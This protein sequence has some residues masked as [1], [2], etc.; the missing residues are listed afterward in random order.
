MERKWHHNLIHP[1]PLERP[2]EIRE[3]VKVFTAV[4]LAVIFAVTALAIK[5][6]YTKDRTQKVDATLD[7][8]KATADHVEAL[9]GKMATDIPAAVEGVTNIETGLTGM[10]GTVTGE[11]PPAAQQL[12]AN[13]LSVQGVTDD[14]RDKLFGSNGLVPGLTDSLTAPGKKVWGITVG[15]GLIPRA[16]M[17]LG[18]VDDAVLVLK[19]GA[20]G[21][22]TIVTDLD[23]SL[24]DADKIEIS[25][26][27]AITRMYPIEA[28]LTGLTDAT[29][30]TA[31]DVHKFVHTKLFP[32]PVHGFWPHVWQGVQYV[33]TPV[34]DGLKL[35]FAVRPVTPNVTFAPVTRH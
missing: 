31:E 20:E 10:I 5:G 3:W 21:L 1:D 27:G 34:F 25:A 16:T 30:G 26:D 29:T 32:P 18:H 15:Q 12:R 22:P 33:I 4:G 19:R 9:T 24:K 7:A 28:N 2:R 14:A 6:T 11:I 23:N 35:Y 8:V 17:A 13:L